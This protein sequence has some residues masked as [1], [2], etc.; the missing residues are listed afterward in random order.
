MLASNRG[1]VGVLLPRGF[2][3]SQ[4]VAKRSSRTRRQCLMSTE[5]TTTT[6]TASCIEVDVIVP[7]HNAAATLRETLQSA[8]HQ[9]PLHDVVSEQQSPPPNIQIYVCCYDDGSTDDSWDLLKKIAQEHEDEED[10]KKNHD[11]TENSKDNKSYLPSSILIARAKDGVSRGAGFA[12]NRAVNLRNQNDST[13]SSC[14][15]TQHRFVAMLDSD[16][17]MQPTRIAA[18]VQY[19]TRLDPD[20]RHRTLVGCTFERDPPDSTWHY[21]NWANTL[22]DERLVLEQFREVTL[23][24]PTWMMDRSWFEKLGGYLEAPPP[25]QQSRFNMDDFITQLNSQDETLLHVVH[26]TFETDTTL[27]VAEDTRFFY[28]HLH[29]GGHLRLLRTAKPLMIYKHRLGQSQ[30]SLT[31]RKLLFHL[32]ARAFER[33]ILQRQE[34]KPKQPWSKFCVWGA[35][36]DGKDFIK[37]LQPEFRE[38]IACLVDVDPKKIDVGE[39]YNKDLGVRIP[40]VHFSLLVRDLEARAR[41]AESYEVGTDSNEPGF[42]RIQKSQDSVPNEATTT[43]IPPWKR[44]KVSRT[45]GFD[46]SILPTLPVVVC[47]AMYRTGGAL[48]HNVKS[49]GRSE[50]IDLWHFS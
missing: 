39:Y 12:R 43:A 7:V 13:P 10:D 38:R 2:L 42:G 46:E 48:E 27:R 16:D 37:A 21:A 20:I 18:Q 47:V 8:L 15:S 32:R 34:K 9:V 28:K 5:T 11:T 17:L 3:H 14:C 40:I 33:M 23:L 24:Q 41:L 6:T 44:R 29:A 19:L 50:G 35:G 30:S 45:K 4:P 31:P 49:I 22:T 26:P 1:R 36:R 25:P